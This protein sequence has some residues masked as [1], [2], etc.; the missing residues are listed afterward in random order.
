MDDDLFGPSKP[1]AAAGGAAF[2][3]PFADDDDLLGGP[4]KGPA[5]DDDWLLGGTAGSSAPA[6]DAAKNSSAG[7]TGSS[8]T[9]NSAARTAS[10][11]PPLS[12]V[13]AFNISPLRETSPA[14]APFLTNRTYFLRF[15]TV[16]ASDGTRLRKVLALTDEKLYIML[17]DTLA[18]ERQLLLTNVIGVIT[19]SIAVTKRLSK[20]HELHAIVQIGGDADILLSFHKDDE[21]YASQ[22]QGEFTSVLSNLL[23]AYDVVLPVA[24]LPPT[25][26][27]TDLFH[28]KPSSLDERLRRQLCEAL[29][30]RSELQRDHSELT[31]RDS[32]LDVSMTSLKSSTTGKAAADILGEIQ[33][34]RDVIAKLGQQRDAAAAAR[35]QTNAQI[36]TLS[37]DLTKEQASRD[38]QIQALKE[39][40]SKKH[41]FDQ[42]RDFELQKAN[43]KRD[44]DKIAL[45][46][47][48]YDRRAKE[49]G[50]GTFGPAQLPLRIDDLE[51][52]LAAVKAKISERSDEHSR[53]VK[54]LAEN[55]RRAATAKDLLAQLPNE[56]ALLGALKPSEA[57]PSSVADTNLPDTTPMTFTAGGEAGGTPKPAAVSAAPPVDPTR[58]V[59]PDIPLPPKPT[60]AARP[61]DID[62]DLPL[63]KPAAAATGGAKPISVDDDI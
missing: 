19:Q 59:S 61:V 58:P 20:E 5:L 44:M 11:A 36:E 17:R 18:V 37:K 38:R 57:L 33:E 53:R 30:Y 41:L 14:L 28:E 4:S 55:R 42:V 25:E 7:A 46:T 1:S 63:P 2:A 43:H 12:P 3:D 16:C 9:A 60:A 21:N 29:A 45:I 52:L 51:E 50:T 39:E 24:M 49:R 34:L 48:F 6:S 26:K 27:L 47:S 56:I 10:A 22:T 13:R 40:T 62:D 31:R 23:A 15:V 35:A 8:G 54:I 32:Q